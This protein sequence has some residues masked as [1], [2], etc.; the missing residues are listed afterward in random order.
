[1]TAAILSKTEG[2]SLTLDV[3]LLTVVTFTFSLWD[4]EFAQNGQFHYI[5]VLSDSCSLFFL[6]PLQA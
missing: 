5:L 6:G 4:S 1:M 2:D 3:C